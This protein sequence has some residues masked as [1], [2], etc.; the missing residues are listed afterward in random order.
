MK[1]LIIMIFVLGCGQE[2]QAGIETQQIDNTPEV[3]NKIME[4]REYALKIDNKRDLFDCTDENDKQLVYVVDTSEML[5]CDE[6]KWAAIDLKGKDGSQGRDGKDGAQGQTGASGIDG[7]NGTNGIDGLGGVAGANGVN[8]VDG[9][10]G[11]DAATVNVIK[12]DGSILG[13][14]IDIYVSN[15]EYYVLTPA[16]IRLQ[17][18]HSTGV[19][20]NV[21][22]VFA[23]ANCTGEARIMI[24]NGVF[25]NVFV[26]GRDNTTLYKTTGQNLGT[27]VYQ[28]RIPKSNGCQNASGSA[29][30]SH[31]YEQ[32]N[33]MTYPIINTE[34]EN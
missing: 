31:A 22:L 26:D 11:Q 32:I 1:L 9:Q 21:Y 33:G 5:T 12:S 25:G 24:E 2:E 13:R 17:Y 34:I 15:N 8:G 20:R 18:E 23:G 27:F 30:R 10:D 3:Q 29:L 4:P 7:Q 19:L 16:G 28:S 6:H 14:L